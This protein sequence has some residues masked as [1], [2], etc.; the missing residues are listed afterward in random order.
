MLNN[1]LQQM[2]EV[3][4][5]G[6]RLP[7]LAF[8][9][10][11]LASAPSWGPGNVIPEEQASRALSYAFEQGFTWFDTAPSYGAGMAEMRMGQ[12]LQQVPRHQVQ[13]ATKVGWIAEGNT[14]HRDYSREGVLRSLEK[15]LKRLR[16][17]SVD[18]LYVHDPDEYQQQVLD[19]TFPALAD[20]RAQGVIKAIGAG[21]NQWQVPLEF[22][23]HADF[24]CFLIAGRWTLLEQSALPLLDLCS[25]RGIAIFAASI[26][27]S[28]ILA[29]GSSSQGASYNH[30]PASPAIRAHVRAIEEMCH[31]NGVLLQSAATQYPFAHPAVKALVVGFQSD[32][33]VR[34]CLDAL[35]DP[36]PTELWE[37]LRS[38]GLIAQEA[39][40]PGGR[41]AMS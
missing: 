23:K 26:Y 40:L 10:A 32:V 29:T 3:G 18:L 30:A 41:K 38:E 25:S 11:P 9:T 33:Q 35:C 27:N 17:D 31:A 15:S 16:V 37:C 22:A 24:D 6:L 20:L 5:R 12:F 19:E 34:M 14:V 4:Q 13:I 39:P 36:I 8:G 2:V 7:R 21:M 1:H 28:G